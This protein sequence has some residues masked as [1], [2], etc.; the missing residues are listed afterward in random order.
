VLVLV[1][2]TVVL[3]RL[4]V[5]VLDHGLPV[6]PEVPGEDDDVS[7]G[8]WVGRPWAPYCSV[9]GPP[10]D[11]RGCFAADPEQ[12]VDDDHPSYVRT[13]SGWEGLGGGSGIGGQRQNP[14]GLSAGAGCELE[15]DDNL[16]AG[17]SDPELQRIGD[18]VEAR[19]ESEDQVFVTAVTGTA[20]KDAHVRTSAIVLGNDRQGRP[21]APMVFAVNPPPR[22]STEVNPPAV[23]SV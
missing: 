9:G 3:V 23:P 7:V 10:F 20:V 13:D 11:E 4:A 14:L 2:V 5:W 19:T 1:L 12:D 6:L 8:D 21:L 17:S 22:C 18:W 16:L 15:I